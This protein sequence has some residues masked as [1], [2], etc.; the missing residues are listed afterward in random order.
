MQVVPFSKISGLGPYRNLCPN[1]IKKIYKKIYPN[2][3][4]KIYANIYKYIQDIQDIYKMS[5]GGQAAVA[6]PGPEPRAIYFD[7]FG[8]F[9]VPEIC[10]KLTDPRPYRHKSA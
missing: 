6:R 4:S 10:K 8:H 9:L 2:I 5:G 7:I 1:H 3:Y